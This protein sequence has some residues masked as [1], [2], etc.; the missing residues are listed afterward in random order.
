MGCHVPGEPGEDTAWTGRA[1][2]MVWVNFS[3]ETAG[4]MRARGVDERQGPGRG[5]RK[6]AETKQ[7]E[8]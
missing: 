7:Q 2:E 6:A 5:R 3:R 4:A 1:G 8:R